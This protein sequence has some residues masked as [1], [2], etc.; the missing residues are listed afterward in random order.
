MIFFRNFVENYLVMSPFTKIAL[1][2]SGNVAASF[3]N[4]LNDNDIYVSCVFVRNADKKSEA[5]TLFGDI[6]VTDYEELFDCDL[7]IIAVNDDAI[8][9]VVSNLSDYKGLLL[10]TSGT[11]PSSV[12]NIVDNYGVIYPIQTL[13]KNVSVDFRAIPLLITASS[14][15]NLA[16][17]AS[18]AESLSDVVVECPDEDR[19]FIHASAVYVS[20]FV[21]VLLQIGEKLLINKGYKISLMEPLVN[22]TINKAFA[23]GPEKALTGPARRGD[24]ETINNHLVLLNNYENEK[25]IYE[26]LTDYIIKKYRNNEEL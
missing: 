9:E 26:L 16:K 2:G 4:A 13:T 14:S 1:I 10:H 8:A 23:L 22:E 24:S 15:D 21:N 7:I 6:V 3:F 11:K 19:I 17:L 5:E 25:K 20:N 12:L 18:F